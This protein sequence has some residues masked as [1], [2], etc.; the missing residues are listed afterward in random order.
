MPLSRTYQDPL[1]SS[2]FYI[3]LL[4]IFIGMQLEFDGAAIEGV[5]L[6]GEIVLRIIQADNIASPE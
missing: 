3:S 1:R 2:F 5:E 6:K 4:S